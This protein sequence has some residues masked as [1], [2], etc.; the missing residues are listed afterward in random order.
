MIQVDLKSPSMA[1]ETF[2]PI[3]LVVPVA[4]V[5]SAIDYVNAHPKP[6]SLYVF[7]K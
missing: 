6:L 1:E 2:G 5:Q 3:L 4:D 7:A